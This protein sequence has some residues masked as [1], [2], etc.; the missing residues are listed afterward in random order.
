M[1]ESQEIIKLTKLLP[2]KRIEWFIAIPV[3]GLWL[4]GKAI[5]EE[6]FF[7][8]GILAFLMSKSKSPLVRIFYSYNFFNMGLLHFSNTNAPTIKITQVFILGIFFAGFAERICFESAIATH[9]GL[10]ISGIL[11]YYLPFTNFLFS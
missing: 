1:K 4:I 2:I 3:S 5:G 11:L 9:I 7:R 8:R 10:N 6:L